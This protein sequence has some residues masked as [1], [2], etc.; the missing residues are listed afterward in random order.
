[1]NFESEC[2]IYFNNYLNCIIANN[3]NKCDY[4]GVLTHCKNINDNWVDKK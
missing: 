3:E 4:K 1:M 2:K